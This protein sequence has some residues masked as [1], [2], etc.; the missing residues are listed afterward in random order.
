M[1]IDQLQHHVLHYQFKNISL[2]KQA[3][4]HPSITK[5]KDNYER[6]EFLG[7]AV[8]GTIISKHLL[9]TYP[10]DNEGDLARKKSYLVCTKYLT[11][12][13]NKINIGQYMELSHG[14]KSTSGTS[15]ANNLANCIE[16]MIGALFL[17]GGFQ[18]SENF[19]MHYWQEGLSNIIN[20]PIDCKSALQ[21]LLQSQQK[22]KPIYEVI[23]TSGD[24]H[25][26]IFT[27]QASADGISACASGRS[28][29]EAQKKSAK[30]L[31]DQLI[32]HPS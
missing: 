1:N 18:A 13:A 25:Q 21:E 29:K 23:N 32:Q 14:E 2:L 26:L 16:A 10:H 8:I 28:K 5:Q 20:T 17:D 4:T 11:K 15:N 22:E 31:L 24:Q 12:M 7:D 3:L 19:V 6:L 30:L 27:I 9:I